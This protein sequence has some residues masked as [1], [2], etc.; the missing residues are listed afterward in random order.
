MAL[1]KTP[2][3]SLRGFILFLVIYTISKRQQTVAKMD[4]FNDYVIIFKIDV[5]VGKVPKGTH[6][7]GNEPF[8][9]CLCAFFRYAQNG[10]L[11][12]FTAAEFL[13]P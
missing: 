7:Q 4:V 10:Y 5:K 12:I 9:H 8:T 11:R 6:S 3:Q 2:K 1:N 13:K